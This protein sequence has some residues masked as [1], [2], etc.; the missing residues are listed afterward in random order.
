MQQN[1]N[2]RRQGTAK[3]EDPE[4][5]IPWSEHV[6]PDGSPASYF[7]AAAIRRYITGK[8]EFLFF[9]DFMA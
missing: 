6:S 3:G 2:I 5:A 1:T 9:D 7:K 4:P 8:D